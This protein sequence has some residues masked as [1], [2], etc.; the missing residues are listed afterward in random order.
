VED[1]PQSPEGKRQQLEDT[2]EES[3]QE[4]RSTR[5]KVRTVLFQSQQVEEQEQALKSQSVSRRRQSH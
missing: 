4:R 3:T 2:E 5:A 1:S